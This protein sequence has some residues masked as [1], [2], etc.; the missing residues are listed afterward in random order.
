MIETRLGGAWVLLVAFGSGCDECPPPKV[1]GGTETE[2]AEVRGAISS[3][4]DSLAEPICVDAVRLAPSMHNK[5]GRYDSIGRRIRILEGMPPDYTQRVVWHELCHG[6]QR[7]QDVDVS[8]DDLWWL[9]HP[10]AY[11]GALIPLEAFAQTCEVGAETLHLF[12]D[13]CP[14]DTH[15]TA[16]FALASEPF[17]VPDTVVERSFTWSE[18]AHQ[19]GVSGAEFSVTSTVDDALR[20]E[21]LDD[22]GGRSVSYVDPWTAEL[23]PVGLPVSPP[24]PPDPPLGTTSDRWAATDDAA[25]LVVEAVAPNGG[26]AERLVYRD[27][28]G[29][30]RVGCVRPGEQP[31]AADG[32]LW[33]A[34]ADG[35]TLRWGTWSSHD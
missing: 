20:V 18:V 11:Q 31:F 26:V 13:I 8:D 9:E 16:V 23:R 27:A 33:S 3:F 25:L 5:N 35:D 7:Q 34:F 21:F 19:T 24:D 29:T 15:G 6:L 17:V 4:M 1:S 22:A 10:G 30:T 14:A 28:A 32:A 12:G 2:R